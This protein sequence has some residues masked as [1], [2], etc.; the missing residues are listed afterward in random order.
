MDDFD[1]EGLEEQ[2]ETAEEVQEAPKAEPEQE[3][4]TADRSVPL[5]QRIEREKGQLKLAA[6]FMADYQLASA[7]YLAEIIQSDILQTDE[8]EHFS[9]KW[10]ENK[11]TFPKV[12]EAVQKEAQK[13]SGGKSFGVRDEIVLGWVRHIVIDTKPET[14]KPQ[15]TATPKQQ[16]PKAKPEKPKAEHG[17]EQ[18]KLDFDF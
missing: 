17:V 2:E 10:D 11:W 6:G 5:P 13:Q 3:Q 14:K 15:T 18:L 1:F 12:W 9:K 8:A 16:T 7:N 4:D